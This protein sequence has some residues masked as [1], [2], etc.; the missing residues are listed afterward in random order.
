MFLI[1]QY[2]NGRKVLLIIDEA[3]NLSNKVLEEVRLLSGVETTKEKVLRIILAGQ[4]EL[5]AEDSIRPN[6]AVATA[7]AP[8][9]PSRRSTE[10]ETGNY[11]RHRLRGGRRRTAARS[12]RRIPIP[13]I[14]R[15]TGGIP[16]LINTLCDTSML[17]AFAQDHATTSPD[18][19]QRGDRRTAVAGV[20]G[21]TRTRTC[22]SPSSTTPRRTCAAG[23]P[24]R[25]APEGRQARRVA[26]CCRAAS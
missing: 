20:L 7:R 24:D 19:L 1:E 21:A 13:P 12:S 6:C 3:Q 2:A 15:Y 22:R 18:D 11:V 10:Q 5:N 26:A 23:R 16:R 14:Y 8:A 17:A 4:P 9:F 25:A